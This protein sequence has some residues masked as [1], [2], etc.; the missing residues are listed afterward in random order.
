M[1]RGAVSELSF[2]KLFRQSIHEYR[3][4][5]VKITDVSFSGNVYETEKAKAQKDQKNAGPAF[6]EVLDGA[7]TSFSA[8]SKTNQQLKAL[9]DSSPEIR[10]DKVQEFKASVATGSYQVDHEKLAK[11]ILSDEVLN[12]IL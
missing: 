8:V 3:E 6:S 2:P 4:A 12:R 11:N 5:S 9:Y 7:A 10:T 1:D